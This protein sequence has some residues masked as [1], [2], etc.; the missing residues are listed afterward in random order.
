MNTDRVFDLRG[1]DVR[2]VLIVRLF[3]LGDIVLTLPLVRDIRSALPG[4]W[5]G[6]VTDQRY[7]GALAGDTRL[8]EVISMPDSIAGR[9]REIRRLRTRKIEAVVDLLSSPRSAL[10]TR[11]CGA[12]RRIGMD[13]GRRNSYYHIVLPRAVIRNGRRVRCYTLDANLEL[14]RLLGV[15]AGSPSCRGSSFAGDAAYGTDHGDRPFGFPA[16]E[17]APG[18]P[19]F[20]VD[21]SGCRGL[22][23][24]AAGARYPSKSWPFPRFVELCSRLTGELALRPVII[25]GPGEER[26]ARE[27][28]ES[29]AGC[30]LPP[31]TGIAE[32]GALIGDLDIL[33]GID[34][35]PKHIA[36]LMGVPTVTLFGPTD[37]RIWDPMNSLHRAVFH[38]VE[39]SEGC[40]DKDCRENICMESI[41]VEDVM[42]EIRSMIDEGIVPRGGGRA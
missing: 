23:G 27:L 19:G 30:I 2:S 37:P 1:A 12:A 33:V 21:R 34:S 42:G 16:A 14:G 32:A 7:A 35:G 28:A 36:V 41:T 26:Q 5:I 39:C 15:S 22:A 11:L 6:Y 3:A 17:T 13:T 31:E 38:P 20:Q 10:V 4:A 25:W 18:A 40:R 8:D 29:A 9:L 24:I